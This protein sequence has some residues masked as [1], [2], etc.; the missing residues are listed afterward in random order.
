MNQKFTSKEEIYQWCTD[1]LIENFTINDDLTVDVEDNVILYLVEMEELPVNFGYVKG[2]FILG[3]NNLETLEGVPHTVGGDFICGGN[4]IRDLDF[5]PK[6]IDSRVIL[7][8]NPLES[9]TSPLEHAN[10]IIWISKPIPGLSYLEIDEHGYYK[11]NIDDYL[12]W[13]EGAKEFFEN[14][15]FII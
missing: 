7:L 3:E 5:F 6:E 11:Y 13:N 9:Y 10:N 15:D 1:H 8:N 12:I 2:D 4:N 14:N